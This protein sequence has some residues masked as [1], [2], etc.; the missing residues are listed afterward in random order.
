MK[1]Y[2]EVAIGIGLVQFRAKMFKATKDEGASLGNKVKS[3]CVCGTA[4]KQ[5]IVCPTCAAE[6]SGWS[7]VPLRGFEVAKDEYVTVPTKEWESAGK[8]EGSKALGIE[9]VVDFKTLA[10]QFVLSE[11]YYLLPDEQGLPVDLKLFRLLVEALDAEGWALLTHAA[12]RGFPRR[13]ALIA[14]RMEN[15][16]VA[17]TVQDKNAAPYTAPTVPVSDMERQQL[18]SM[19]KGAM[20]TDL[21][22]PGADDGKL[23]LMSAKVEEYVAKTLGGTTAGEP[24]PVLTTTD[25]ATEPQGAQ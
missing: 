1:P 14:D 17:Y 9:K 13:L 15:A 22:F 19:L 7:T 11:P 6:Y 16:L 5:R 21:S 18:T 25:G 24:A 8:V 3:L 10:T 20:T 23:R 2:Q 12:L 4:P